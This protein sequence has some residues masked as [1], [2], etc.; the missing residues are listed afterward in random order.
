M[1]E[2]WNKFTTWYDS[3]DPRLQKVLVGLAGFVLGALVV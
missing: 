2:Y 1:T 3:L